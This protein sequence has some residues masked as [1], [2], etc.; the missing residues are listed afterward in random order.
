V[1]K[2]FMNDGLDGRETIA[3][4]LV[5]GEIAVLILAMLS[6]YAVLHSGLAG[7]IAWSLAAV[8]LAGG[9]SLAWGRLAGRPL[10][11]WCLLLARFLVRTRHARVARWRTRWR[12]WRVAT[13][14]GRVM[15]SPR[16]L[17]AGAVVIPLALRHIA[18]EPVTARRPAVVRD[19]TPT[20]TGPAG[21]GRRRSHVVGFFSLCG[22]TGR[23]TLAGEACGA[24]RPRRAQP[25]RGSPP[26]DSA[27]TRS[28]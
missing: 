1:D 21:E 18:E 24:T 7:A 19:E 20:A 14:A 25:R 6:G 23:T 5:A 26:G 22:G 8:L 27:A 3:F 9:A 17:Q 11:D 12:H 28:R 10:L 15:R 13:E 2:I 4:G 16:P